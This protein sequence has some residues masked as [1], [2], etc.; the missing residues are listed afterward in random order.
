M[1]TIGNLLLKKKLLRLN[2]R[3]KSLTN[4]SRRSKLIIDEYVDLN[5]IHFDA[6]GIGEKPCHLEAFSIF[7][8]GTVHSLSRI[9]RYC[10]IGPQ[11]RIGGK[12]HPTN[13][14]STHTF[15]YHNKRI[16]NF[17]RESV[18]FQDPSPPPVI[19][20][21]VWIGSDATILRGVTI[22]DG[23][24]VASGAMVTKDVQPYEV[25]GGVPAKHIEF[26]FNKNTIT[27]LLKCSWW[28]Y[29]PDLLIGLRFDDINA[30][31]NTL[32]KRI[33]EESASPFFPQTVKITKRKLC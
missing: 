31:L 12:G 25:V 29:H 22:G 1:I 17:P 23:A 24:I 13:W 11:V 4:I 5:Q 2:I 6:G 33:D 20:N 14:L 16:K 26:R 19:G 28:Q 3:I 18:A 27:R 10:S 9:G 32:E 15:Q 21:D 8:D 7:M 30:S